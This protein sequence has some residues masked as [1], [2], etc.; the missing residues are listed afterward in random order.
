[1]SIDLD[2]VKLSTSARIKGRQTLFRKKQKLHPNSQ[3]SEILPDSQESEPYPISQETEALA[4]FRP[5]LKENPSMR[6]RNSD[7]GSPRIRDM[8]E[9]GH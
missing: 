8:A 7:P 6:P 5:I 1:M 2:V 3:V 9:S 4:Y